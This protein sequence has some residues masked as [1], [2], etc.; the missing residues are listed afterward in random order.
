MTLEQF[1]KNLE[2]LKDRKQREEQVDD[3]L[4]SLSPDITCGIS[5][6]FTEWESAFV[7]LLSMAVED[8]DWVSYWIYDCQFGTNDLADSVRDKNGN[9]IPLRTAEDLYNFVTGKT[10][11]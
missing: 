11:Y 3:I 4:D 8:T 1:T 2:W 7:S 6:A 5:G 9:H 10:T